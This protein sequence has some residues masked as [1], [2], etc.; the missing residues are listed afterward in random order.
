MYLSRKNKHQ[1]DERIKFEDEGHMYWIDGCNHN[2]KST[3]TFI[4]S[5]FGE[6]DMSNAI[7]GIIQSKRYGVD[8]TYEYYQMSEDMIRQKWKDANQLGTFLH[9]TIEKILN[10][11]TLNDTVLITKELEYFKTFWKE[12]EL[13]WEPYRTEWLVFSE[14]HRITGSIDCVFQDKVTKNLIIVDWKR[15]KRLDKI[16]FSGEKFGKIPLDLLQD[17]NF[18]HY[19]LQLNMYKYILENY[20]GMKVQSL[21]LLVLHP[22]ND[23]YIKIEIMDMINSIKQILEYRMNEIRKLPEELS[24]NDLSQSQKKAYDI[25]KSGENIFI[26]GAAGNGKSLLVNMFCRE[27]EKRRYIGLTSTTGIS[28]I[29]IGGSTVHSYLGIGLGELPAGELYDFVL[30]KRP[31]Y[32]KDRW[33]SL[34]TLIIDEVS[35]LTPEL[36]D[37]LDYIGR[38]MRRNDKPFGGMQI[39]LTGDYMQ[40]P[41][42]GT[43]KLCF[44]SKSW[45][46]CIKHTVVLTDTFRQ[47][48]DKFKKALNEARFGCLSDE[49]VELLQSREDVILDNVHGIEPTKIYGINASVDREN[50]ERLHK[51]ILSKH[52]TE[53][54][55]YDLVYSIYKKNLSNVEERVQKAC[56][57]PRKLRICVGA[58]VMLLVNLDTENGFANGSRGVVVTFNPSG[59]PMVK[60][61]NGRIMTI[62]YYTWDVVENKEKI[63]D[64][65]QLPLK[66]AYAVTTHKS[67]GQ[68]LDL[69]CVD[70]TKVFEYGQAYVAISRVKNLEGLSLKNFKRE[71]FF[72]NPKIV[73]FYE[74]LEEI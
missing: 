7:K 31:K 65:T 25:M 60:F 41:A 38:H 66:I 62:D 57:A 2:L 18:I 28:A 13:I 22:N 54:Y 51:L 55:E 19:S 63:L 53:V 10:N 50:D 72:A 40:L 39:I 48:D 45:K 27:F 26:T 46:E 52:G 67:Q 68:T 36:F 61:M 9:N 23:T 69:A 49:S 35:M 64:I 1:R 37:K 20:Y 21:F 24:Y 16:S 71:K 43:E 6:F 15:V 5:F 56:L 4:H 34:N 33:R 14:I 58:Q 44:E 12:H 47:T 74:D 42:I 59:Y 30:M 8:E 32:I 3:T 17:C 11:E 70:L 73:K 29:L